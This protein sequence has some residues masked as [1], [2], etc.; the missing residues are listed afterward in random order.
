M[1]PIFLKIEQLINIQ[2]YHYLFN[3]SITSVL[4]D[5]LKVL[6]PQE[7]QQV[8]LKSSTVHFLSSSP[9]YSLPLKQYSVSW[10]PRSFSIIF[11]VSSLDGIRQN[12]NVTNLDYFSILILKNTHWKSFSRGVSFAVLIVPHASSLCHRCSSLWL[13]LAH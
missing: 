3:I 11:S 13:L 8:I 2:S 1:C 10:N 5:L 12:V 4:I 7:H 6:L 9:R